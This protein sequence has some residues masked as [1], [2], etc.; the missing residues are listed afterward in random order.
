M[1]RTLSLLALSALALG[2][3]TFPASAADFDSV[4]HM[5]LDASPGAANTGTSA[6][7]RLGD[8]LV[9]VAP[10]G[11][12]GW[13]LWT[14]DGTK[15]GT[16]MLRDINPGVANSDPTDLTV[17]KGKVYFRASDG[18]HGFELWRTDGTTSGTTMV[19]DAYPGAGDG[20]ESEGE[21]VAT[22]T[23]L[24]FPG[25]SDLDGVE[26]WTSDGTSFGTRLILDAYS[27][28]NGTHPNGLT[29]WGDK[30]IF[31]A[32]DG[33]NGEEP[34]MSG[35]TAATTSI[36]KDI[37]PDGSSTPEEFTVVSPTKVFFTAYSTS[38]R[39]IWQTNGTAAGTAVVDAASTGTLPQH[40]VALGDRV[41][42]TALTPGMGRELWGTDG[43]AAHTALVKDINPIAG[44]GSFIDEMT[45]YNGRAY[46]RGAGADQDDELWRTDGTSAGTFQL[47][48][49]ALT[50]DSTP[51]GFISEGGYLYFNA[52]ADGVG[53]ELFRTNGTA[54]GT[55]MV[56]DIYPGPQ[57]SSPLPMQA[58]S[59]TLFFRASD[60][61]HGAELWAYTTRS[62]ITRGYPK[63]SYSR[64]A[65]S[66]RKIYLTVKVSATGTTPIG[67]V[68][69]KQ[70][71]TVVG[72]GTLS[73][74]KASIRITKKF[75]KGKH[76]VRAY[77]S[78][79][80][81]ARISHSTLLTIKV[82]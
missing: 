7:V 31:Q 50:G 55:M 23:R 22:S 44:A 49:I 11:T 82:R 61:A 14:S 81:R 73:G 24:Y 26:L 17:L 46:F 19:K 42:Y 67:K 43:T 47:K 28:A 48:N 45:V 36:L 27:G 20:V 72:T 10:N 4:P 9:Y 16:K 58:V 75:G 25:D 54:S 8:R 70:G 77:Y 1:R 38:G 69:L 66:H 76:H 15:N 57:S 41:L 79:S 32:D 33:D 80:V 59:N 2:S 52:R 21:L 37:R 68:V 64:S 51:Y 35:G 71:T 74:G 12:S 56:R 18:T 29:R 62:S 63:S 60:A 65:G 53:S 5:V 78:G 30:V 40:L 34:W 13:E 39:Q 3:L 6:S